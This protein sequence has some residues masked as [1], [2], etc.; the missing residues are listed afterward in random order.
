[1]GEEEQKKRTNACLVLLAISVG[2]CVYIAYS[3]Y[4]HNR[5]LDKNLFLMSQHIMNRINR[6]EDSLMNQQPAPVEQ[7]QD[8]SNEQMYLNELEPQPQPQYQPQYQPPHGQSNVRNNMRPYTLLD[9]SIV[10]HVNHVDNE[11]LNSNN[12]YGYMH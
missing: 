8:Y 9:N 5:N 4:M 11:K 7:E 10:Q 2:L 1:M 12:L 6:L 3:M